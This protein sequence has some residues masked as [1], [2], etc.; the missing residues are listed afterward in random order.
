MATV[1]DFVMMVSSSVSAAGI[2]YGA[3]QARAALNRIEENEERSLEN[4]EA[5]RQEGIISRRQNG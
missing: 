1:V 3:S 4:R 2:I 5:L